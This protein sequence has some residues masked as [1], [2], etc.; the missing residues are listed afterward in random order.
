MQTK[1]IM[2]LVMVLAAYNPNPPIVTTVM[3]HATQ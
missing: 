1:I 2:R 3:K